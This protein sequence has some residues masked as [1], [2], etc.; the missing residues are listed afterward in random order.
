MCL[1]PVDKP[2]RIPNNNPTITPIVSDNGL[3]NVKI[4]PMT[5]SMCEKISNACEPLFDAL[6]NLSISWRKVWK[7]RKKLIIN[8]TTIVE[9]TATRPALMMPLI[10][11]A[12]RADPL[13]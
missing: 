4:C 10:I 7:A 13:H 9:K 8:V 11:F 2:A 12:A 1:F 3:E 5:E 6:T